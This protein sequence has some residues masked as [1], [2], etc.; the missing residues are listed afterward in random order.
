MSSSTTL[1]RVPTPVH[2]RI[3][4]AAQASG[5][6]FGQIIDRGLDLI[7]RERFWGEVAALTPDAE[8]AREFA[9]WDAA[10]VGHDS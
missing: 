5:Q 1:I 2:A 4:A 6:T 3:R 8:Y 9:A 10:D 7:E